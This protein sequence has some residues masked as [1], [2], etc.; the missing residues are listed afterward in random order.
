MCI[1][2]LLDMCLAELHN[3]CLA[4]Q[5]CGHLVISAAYGVRMSCPLSLL[6][7]TGVV[8]LFIHGYNC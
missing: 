5:R 6:S 2:Y 4:L 7:S 3:M 8:I 1:H